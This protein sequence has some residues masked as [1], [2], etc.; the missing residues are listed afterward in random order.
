MARSHCRAT[1]TRWARRATGRVSPSER[2]DRAVRLRRSLSAD[3]GDNCERSAR[4]EWQHRLSI[5][6]SRQP[7][8]HEFHAQPARPGLWSFELQTGDV[9]D[10]ITTDV[11]DNNGNTITDAG[12]QNVYDFENHLVQRGAVTVVYDGDGNRVSETAGGVTTHYLVDT[13]NP[14][15]YAQ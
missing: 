12:T 7:P 6:R 4:G 14:T 5:R 2:K 1:P 8:E 10:R 15:G 9:N 11:Y 13:Q 3:L